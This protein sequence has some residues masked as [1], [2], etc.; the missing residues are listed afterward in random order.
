[1]QNCK[2]VH[3]HAALHDACRCACWQVL[4]CWHGSVMYV[5]LHKLLT[6]VHL[7]FNWLVANV[8]AAALPLTCL[9]VLQIGLDVARGL[10]YLHPA[11]VHRDLKPQNVLLEASGRAK[12]ADFGISRY[13]SCVHAM[14][15]CL[16]WSCNSTPCH[17]SCRRCCHSNVVIILVDTLYQMTVDLWVYSD[18]LHTCP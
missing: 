6:T 3:V 17:A 9:Q 7:W 16:R 8:H 10:A 5:R 18:C 15:W 1:V 4:R 13:D 14:R 12:I 11:V 2:G